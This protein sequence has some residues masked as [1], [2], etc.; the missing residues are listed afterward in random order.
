MATKRAHFAVYL[1]LYFILNHFNLHIGNLYSLLVY[2]ADMLHY[3]TIYLQSVCSR[4][5]CR[6][7]QRVRPDHSLRRGPVPRERQ[8]LRHGRSVAGTGPE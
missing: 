7:R 2:L 4:K 8:N 5:W 6:S 3:F 1:Y